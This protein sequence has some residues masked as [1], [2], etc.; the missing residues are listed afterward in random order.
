MSGY[1]PPNKQNATEEKVIGRFNK[2]TIDEE[3]EEA[4]ELVLA[5]DETL[6]EE[7]NDERPSS[8]EPIEVENEVLNCE[9]VK[10]ELADEVQ[11]FWKCD[12]VISKLVKEQKERDAKA[13]VLW[14]PRV[15]FPSDNP[16]DEDDSKADER[17]GKR[18]ETVLLDRTSEYT[19]TEEA[20]SDAFECEPIV[21]SDLK[22][23][24]LDDDEDMMEI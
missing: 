4:D 21:S 22:I 9:K 19:V 18:S 15:T 11:E 6:D 23:I 12:D 20:S 1:Q 10:F 5:L 14:Q 13:L 2:L 7:L 24:E 16:S 8:E 3:F 17:Q